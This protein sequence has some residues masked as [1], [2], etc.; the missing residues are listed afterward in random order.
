MYHHT[1]YELQVYRICWGLAKATQFLHGFGIAHRDL[2][3]DNFLVDDGE[4][5]ITDLGES[6]FITKEHGDLMKAVGTPLYM[7]MCGCA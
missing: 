6:R 4:I 2:K 7:G 3:P 1:P 5:L